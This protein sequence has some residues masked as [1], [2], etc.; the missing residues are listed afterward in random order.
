[1]A[2]LAGATFRVAQGLYRQRAA[3][4]ERRFGAGATKSGA[5]VRFALRR[6]ANPTTIRILPAC[7]RAP[8]AAPTEWV[9]P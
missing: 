6:R 5:A 7:R 4:L 8:R 9:K 3:E 1:M 2:L